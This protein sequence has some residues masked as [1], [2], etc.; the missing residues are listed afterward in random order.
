M[1]RKESPDGK[2]IA[3]LYKSEPRQEMLPIITLHRLTNGFNDQ[4]IFFWIVVFE[5]TLNQQ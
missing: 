5:I 3:I 2:Y 1:L 4:P